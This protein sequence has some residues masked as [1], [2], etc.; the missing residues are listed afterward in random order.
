MNTTSNTDANSV[1]DDFS[2]WKSFLGEKVNQAHQVGMSDDKITDA[3]LNLGSY[4]A[5]QVDPKNPQERLLKQ[6]WDVSSK[7][8]QKVLARTVINLVQQ[9]PTT[10]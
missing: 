1:M 5:N 8:D 10:V 7:E 3:A 9:Q 2:K 6:M 4:L